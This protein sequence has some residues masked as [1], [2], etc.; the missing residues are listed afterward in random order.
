MTTDPLQRRGGDDPFGRALFDDDLALPARPQL[1]R[2]GAVHDVGRGPWIGTL[3]CCT[4]A[5]GHDGP[6]AMSLGDQ[7][8]P[9]Y[10]REAWE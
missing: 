9:T 5:V 2:C 6:H 10:W 3:A 8:S 1:R 4:R 7:D